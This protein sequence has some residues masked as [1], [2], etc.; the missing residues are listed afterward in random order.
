MVS[1]RNQCGVAG[2]TRGASAI[3]R[4]DPHGM[5]IGVLM[6]IS[7]LKLPTTERGLHGDRVR[8]LVAGSLVGRA[9]ADHGDGACQ[10][11]FLFDG[12]V[13]G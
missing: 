2:T 1:L 8:L 13:L 5:A 10:R 4:K 9:A 11:D 12:R 3:S 6:T 7:F